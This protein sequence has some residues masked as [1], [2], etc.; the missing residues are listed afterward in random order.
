MALCLGTEF[1]L[2]D[3]ACSNTQTFYSQILGTGNFIGGS[4][5]PFCDWP[6]WS[7]ISPGQRFSEVILAHFSA[8]LTDIRDIVSLMTQRINVDKGTQMFH[9]SA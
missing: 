6:H 7:E 5:V 3:W 4:W 1:Q 2:T 9:I 8:S